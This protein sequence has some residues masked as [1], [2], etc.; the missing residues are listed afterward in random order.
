MSEVRWRDVR[1]RCDPAEP[2]NASD[3]LVTGTTTADWDALLTLIRAEGWPARYERG[4]LPASA[5][6]FFPG[7]TDGWSRFLRVRPGPDLELVF[8]PWTPDE[9]AADVSLFEVQG[10]ERLDLFCGVLRRLGR[11]LGRRVALYPDGGDDRVPILAYE[12]GPDR[13]VAGHDPF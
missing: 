12:P 10:Q 7:D 6:A 5:A 9:I 8:R 3:L 4:G 13:V 11:A 1:E 2:G